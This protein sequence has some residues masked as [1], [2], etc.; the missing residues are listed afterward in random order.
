LHLADEI[1]HQVMTYQT[2]GSVFT[3]FKHL[4]QRSL[5]SVVEKPAFQG[6]RALM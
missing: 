6:G 4:D 2:S 1:R 5:F 3:T